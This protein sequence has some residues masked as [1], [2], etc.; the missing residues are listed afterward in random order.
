MDEHHSAGQRIN[1]TGIDPRTPVIVRK[2]RRDRGTAARR[3]DGAPQL[4]ETAFTKLVDQPPDGPE[5][6][7]ELKFDGYRSWRESF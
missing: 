1:P 7:H 5:L 4:G 3:S 6:L 2:T